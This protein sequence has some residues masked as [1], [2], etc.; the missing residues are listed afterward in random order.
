MVY[1][2]GENE[3]EE[4]TCINKEL[5][6]AEGKI[7][8]W[9]KP[10]CVRYFITDSKKLKNDHLIFLIKFHFFILLIVN[11]NIYLCF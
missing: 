5:F 10:K 11:L 1:N 9:S 8:N 6:C 3:T 7:L 2:I 4:S